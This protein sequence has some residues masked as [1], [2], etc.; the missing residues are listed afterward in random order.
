LL[1]ALVAERSGGVAGSVS[2]QTPR[3]FNSSAVDVHSHDVATC[4]LENL[5]RQLSKQ[6]KSNHSDNVSQFDVSGSHAMQGDRSDR[7]RGSVIETHF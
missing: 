7:S 4:G 1:H 5:H 3:K 6:A 2:A